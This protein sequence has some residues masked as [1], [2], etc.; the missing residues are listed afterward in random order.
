LA[1]SRQFHPEKRAE[2]TR[3][4]RHSANLAPFSMA[5]TIGGR[6]SGVT[7]TSSLRSG[8]LLR[9]QDNVSL[10]CYV[11]CLS[12]SC[13]C[14]KAWKALLKYCDAYRREFDD[15]A[16][17]AHRTEPYRKSELKSALTAY[18]FMRV[19][20][21]EGDI[22]VRSPRRGYVT[23][24]GKKRKTYWYTVVDGGDDSFGQ[25]ICAFDFCDRLCV[26]VRWFTPTF[27]GSRNQG[28]VNAR[29][30]RTFKRYKLT[31]AYV[32]ID[33]NQICGVACMFPC[34]DEGKDMWYLNSTPIGTS[35][36]QHNVHRKPVAEGDEE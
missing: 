31:N 28:P 16:G 30:R 23:V 22:I 15:R 17:Y 35:Y 26:L 10:Y 9:V 11:R 5:S 3:Q 36:Q 12:Y 7:S 20:G 24:D 21:E 33:A 25:S 2:R 27:R 13:F 8:S 6:F 29:V 32:V 4:Q 14:D 18:Q 1:V 34:F 19:L